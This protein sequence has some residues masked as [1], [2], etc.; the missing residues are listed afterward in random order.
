MV[1]ANLNLTEIARY[2]LGFIRNGTEFL[3]DTVENL[4]DAEILKRGLVIPP[5]P[6]KI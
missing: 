6:K 4:I 1:M 3:R 2:K 5:M